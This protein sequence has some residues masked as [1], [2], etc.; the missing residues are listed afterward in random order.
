MI[1]A[2]TGWRAWTDAPFIHTQI[3]DLLGRNAIFWE[4]GVPLIARVGEA[5][6]A[7]QIVREWL[8]GTDGVTV[9]VYEADWD[10]EDTSAGPHRNKRM[11]LGEDVFDPAYGKPA[12]LLIGFP[13][14]DRPC[15]FY[16]SGT[17]NCIGQAVYRG[18]EVRIPAYR[19]TAQ[20][21]GVADLF[22]AQQEGT[23]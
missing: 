18:I 14:P 17:W 5:K 16:R 19:A 12:D 2:F 3:E 1:V 7:D 11:L 6:G 9:T 13:R 15:A 4:R 23:P 8:H 21:P 22:A 20:M 10:R